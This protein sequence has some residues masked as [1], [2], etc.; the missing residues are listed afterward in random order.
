MRSLALSAALAAAAM[1]GG[2]QTWQTV[3]ISRQIRDSAEQR[4]SIEY[5]AGRLDIRPTSDRVLYSMQLRY[6]EENGRPVHR[7]DAEQRAVTLGISDLSLG[8]GRHI[9]NKNGG[10]LRL[11]FSR[12]V[13]L[14]L[15]LDLGATQAKMDLGGLSLTNLQLESGASEATVDFSAPNPVRL[16]EL[17]VNLGAAG[18]EAT[19]LANANTPSVRVNGG[20][21]GV[22][23]DFGGRWA[24]DISLDAS[25]TLGKLTLH[26][27]REVGVRV[28]VDKLFASFDHDALVKRGNAYYS[29][30]WDRA[31]YHL[32]VKAQMVFGDI[33]L[34]HAPPASQSP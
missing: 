14:D 23:L 17:R 6:D 11:A 7:Y 30:N 33:E 5:G 26:V 10:E 19:N 1:P 25:I 12:A 22:D 9:G 16:R 20:V 34:D 24:Q 3:D 28:E 4:V 15:R 13:P 27:P 21:G 18:F 8:I 32:R 31:T 2:A 29:A